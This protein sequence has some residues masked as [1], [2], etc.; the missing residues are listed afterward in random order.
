MT[1]I[2]QPKTFLQLFDSTKRYLTG[3]SSSL[4]NY[5]IGSRLSVLLES[6]SMVLSQTHGDYYQGLRSAIPTSVYNAFDFNKKVG[7]Q[8]SGTLEFTRTGAA[9]STHPIAVG[10]AILIDGVRFE[11]TV[12][13]EITIGNASSGNIASQC[14]SIGSSGNIANG[15]IDTAVG[16]GTFVNQPDGIEACTNNVAFSG[17]TEEETDDE[18]ITRFRD[19]I[20][21]L[22]RSPVLGLISGARSV[23]GIV[24]ASVVE[25]SPLAGWCT[26]YADDGTGTLSG[27][28]KTEIEKVINGDPADSTNYYGYRAGGIQ[29]RVLAPIVQSESITVDIKILNTALSDPTALKLLAQ[30]ALETY[31]NTLR[32]G[33]DIILTEIS[34]VIK[35]AHDD[36][37]DVEITLPAANVV[38][39]GNEVARTNVVTVTHSI[40]TI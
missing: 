8:A 32:L 13:G 31:V 16:Q 20:A 23:T 30:T 15:A 33:W 37:Y 12:V 22:A 40:V 35:E 38:I 19:F 18:R 4:S 3:E 2:Y 14:A 10:T 29:I 1:A 34:F 24:S 9:P 6:F 21:S 28:L 11:T 5:N 27:A 25:H 26:L 7:I 39:A 17:G 36:I